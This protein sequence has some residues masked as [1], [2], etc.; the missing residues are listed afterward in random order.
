MHTLPDLSELD[1]AQKDALIRQL[2]SQLLTVQ[3]T[4]LQLHGRTQEL[5]GRL[6]LNCKNSSKP[7][8]MDRIQKLQPISLRSAG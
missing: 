6:A 2:W 8:S 1:N 3:A 4:I 5:E 7:P